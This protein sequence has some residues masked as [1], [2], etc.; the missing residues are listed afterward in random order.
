MY[1]IDVYIRTDNQGIRNAVKAILPGESDPRV[2]VYDYR[3]SEGKD[4]FGV[5][6][7]NIM[8]RF[9]LKDDRDSI[10]N[11]LRG[12]EGVINACDEGS[13][14]RPHLCGGNNEPCIIEEGGVYK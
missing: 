13:Y 7:L 8:I 3:W 9:D 12:L 5:E 1:S 6:V 11:S 2:N 14:I 4:E 10:L